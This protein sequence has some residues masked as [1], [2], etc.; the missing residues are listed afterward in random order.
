MNL[1]DRRVNDDLSAVM[2]TRL[3]LIVNFPVET[4]YSN[5]NLTA[6]LVSSM[7]AFSVEWLFRIDTEN[8][9]F[10]ALFTLLHEEVVTV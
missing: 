1:V 10:K 3:M 7:V 8:R 5:S 4:A 9:T 2:L 6:S